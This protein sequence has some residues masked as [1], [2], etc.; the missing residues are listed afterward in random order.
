[1]LC[2]LLIWLESPGRGVEHGEEGGPSGGERGPV[3]LRQLG[4]VGR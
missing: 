1:M 2:R 4:V 3:A